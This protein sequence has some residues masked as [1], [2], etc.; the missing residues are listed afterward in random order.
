LRDNLAVK[1]DA[2]RFPLI[3]V[4]WSGPESD[5]VLEGFIRDCSALAERAV[6]E[7]RHYVIVSIGDSDFGPKQRKR[8]ADWAET[9][10]ESRARWDLG[11]HI[12]VHGAAARGALTAIKWLTPRLSKLYMHPDEATA[13]AAARAS[14]AQ[15][16]TKRTG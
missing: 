10:P 5:E 12:V 6:A 15:A 2:S 14:L 9:A 7:Q 3:V 8:L 16:N 11:N 13:L 1:L 4:H